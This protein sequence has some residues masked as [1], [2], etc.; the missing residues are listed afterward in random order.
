M[1]TYKSAFVNILVIAAGIYLALWLTD[2]REQSEARKAAAM[3]NAQ[4][5]AV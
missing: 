3:L 4:Q 2:M 1:D 5:P